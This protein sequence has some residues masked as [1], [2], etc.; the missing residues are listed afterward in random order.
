MLQRQRSRNGKFFVVI[1]DGIANAYFIPST[2]FEEEIVPE[3]PRHD[4]GGRSEYFVA[5]P[6]QENPHLWSFGDADNDHCL[7]DLSPYY[8]AILSEKELRE[9]LEGLQITENLSA[10]EE[11][12]TDHGTTESESRPY[13]R[14]LREKL[15]GIYEDECAMCGLDVPQLLNVSHIVP[16]SEDKENR[17]NPQNAILL[18]RLHDGLFDRK[19]LTVTTDHEI[20]VSPNLRTGSEI[21]RRWAEQLDGESITVPSDYPPDPEFLEWHAERAGV[22]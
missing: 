9:E 14:W 22:L 12:D 19:L 16:V 5:Y 7:H 3:C 20:R 15:R 11:V 17:A 21:L 13:Q 18:C 2:L 1:H 8:N 10:W 4:G 6:I